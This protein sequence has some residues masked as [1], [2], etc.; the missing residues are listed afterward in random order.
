MA[1]RDHVPDESRSHRIGI[2]EAVLCA[3]KRIENLDRIIKDAQ[4]ANRRLLLTRLS[5]E[6]FAALARFAGDLE[7][8]KKSGEPSS[9]ASFVPAP[10]WAESAYRM[11][12]L[13]LVEQDAPV[14]SS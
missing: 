12:L 8:L 9:L 6:K 1:D 10:T 5:E 14:T 2:D 11:S 4:T 7:S 13:T 3:D